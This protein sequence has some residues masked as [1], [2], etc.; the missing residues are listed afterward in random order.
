LH[1]LGAVGRWDIAHLK[2]EADVSRH[3]HVRIKRIGLEHHGDV[4]V[5]GVHA[6]HRAITDA[7]ITFCRFG[8]PCN[9]VEKR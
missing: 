4:T 8:E 7:H 3:G 6:G 9:D 2:A 5:L 1:G